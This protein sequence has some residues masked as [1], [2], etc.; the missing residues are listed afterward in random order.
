MPCLPAK[1]STETGLPH[2]KRTQ[3]ASPTIQGL[4]LSRGL[5]FSLGLGFGFWVLGPKI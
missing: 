3:D 1:E 4:G 5:G 2:P